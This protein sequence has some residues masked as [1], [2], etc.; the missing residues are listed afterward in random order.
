M[1]NNT[2]VEKL[3]AEDAI[4]F[5]LEHNL[6]IGA[7]RNNVIFGNGMFPNTEHSGT[8]YNP[9]TIHKQVCISITPETDALSVIEGY[10]AANPDIQIYTEIED[11]V[12]AYIAC[13]SANSSYFVPSQAEMTINNYTPVLADRFILLTVYVTGTPNAKNKTFV[14][15]ISGKSIDE[16]VTKWKTAVSN[17]S[18]CVIGDARMLFYRMIKN[19]SYI[20]GGNDQLIILNDKVSIQYDHETVD[21]DGCESWSN[22]TYAVMS[23]NGDKI[24]CQNEI[25]LLTQF[26]RN[27]HL[28][29]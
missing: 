26:H 8:G 14:I 15:D 27:L 3:S 18:T 12:S 5:M 9:G 13:S 19:A 20:S 1:Y 28:F 6:T 29:E 4:K 21:S 23:I 24:Y 16:V 22:N 25:E 2:I 7:I 10:F 11:A 17:T